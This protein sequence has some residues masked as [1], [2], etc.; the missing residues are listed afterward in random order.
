MDVG[1]TYSEGEDKV[2]TPVNTP[3]NE[4]DIAVGQT[5]GTIWGSISALRLRL[6]RKRWYQT[7]WTLIKPAGQWRV[8]HECECLF[9]LIHS[10]PLVSR[11]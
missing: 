4:T 8:I 6:L 9:S 5:A 3:S 10:R 7:S 2:S 1:G 11:F